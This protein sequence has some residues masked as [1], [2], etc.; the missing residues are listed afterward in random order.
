MNSVLTVDEL[1]TEIESVVKHMYYVLDNLDTTVINE[2]RLF[3]CGTIPRDQAKPII[4]F[5]NKVSF[6]RLPDYANQFNLVGVL[7]NDNIHAWGTVRFYF[8]HAGYYF[9][10]IKHDDTVMIHTII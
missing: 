3:D 7:L 8:G 2:L 1:A 9:K 10:H 4:N 5:I 6:D